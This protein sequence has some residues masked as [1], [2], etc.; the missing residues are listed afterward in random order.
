MFRAPLCLSSEETIVLIRHLLYVKYAGDRQVCNL[1]IPDVM[2]IQLIL[3]LMSTG[4]LETC[5]ELE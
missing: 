5:R 2:L 1:H 3:L 4:V